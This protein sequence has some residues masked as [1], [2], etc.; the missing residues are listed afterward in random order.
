M[1][2]D[3]IHQDVLTFF[4]KIEGLRHR[5]KVSMLKLILEKYALLAQSECLLDQADLFKISGRAKQNMSV[6]KGQIHLGERRRKLNFE[7]M[8]LKC[9]VEAV[10][11][12]LNGK[13]CF[14]RLPKFDIRE[15]LYPE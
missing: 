6:D 1:L 10:V 5:D 12:T 9:I 3:E 4:D 7:E 14:K 8:K 13:E 11:D 2:K 15:D